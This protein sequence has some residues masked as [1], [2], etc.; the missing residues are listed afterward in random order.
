MHD[1]L[2][3][4]PRAL[5]R[6]RL[7]H[8]LGFALAGASAA[9]ASAAT[10]ITQNALVQGYYST[11]PN[12]PFGIGQN[13]SGH[14]D[15]TV[16]HLKSDVEAF[17]G[18][19]AAIMQF[20]LPTLPADAVVTNATFSF[21][22][23]FAF[24]GS[25]ALGDT[26]LHGFVTPSSI[27]DPNNLDGGYDLGILRPSGPVN[28]D[29]TWLIGLDLDSLPPGWFAG[30]SFRQV[31]DNCAAAQQPGGYC[32]DI[33]GSQGAGRF[34]VPTLSITYDIP[35]PP[36]PLGSVPEPASWAMMLAGFASIGGV[37]RRRAGCSD[38]K[39]RSP[40]PRLEN[41]TDHAAIRQPTV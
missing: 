10:T 12:G 24:N 19:Y 35:A 3:A 28:V 14:G 17:D 7:A 4:N 23:Y 21:T 9:P 41:D 11:S 29:V 2:D 8:L 40:I 37:M 6:R 5:R 31:A 13:F 33:L 16:G 34:P 38:I 30:F 27:L 32:F 25:A 36:P 22:P 18:Y 1:I 26:S 15:A 20:A 39:S